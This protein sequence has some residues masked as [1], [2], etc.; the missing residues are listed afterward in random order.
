[1]ETEVNRSKALIAILL[2]AA[3]FKAAAAAQERPSS[4]AQANKPL[5]NFVAFNIHDYYVTELSELDGQNANTLWMR[6]AQPFGKWL[7]RGSLPVSRV[8]AGLDTTTSGLG[9]FNAFLAYLIDTGNPAKSFGI[10]K[11]LKSE[12][13][14]YNAFFEPQFTFLDRGAVQPELQLFVGFNM[15]FH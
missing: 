14:V 11:V 9:D 10:G 5:A 15:Q 7:F 1:M 2:Q 3:M 12:K 13:T 6:H 4:G 8:P